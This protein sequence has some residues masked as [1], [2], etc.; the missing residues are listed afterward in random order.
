MIRYSHHDGYY[1]DIPRLH[2]TNES[3]I[4]HRV[5]IN[6]VFGGVEHDDDFDEDWLPL[7]FEPDTEFVVKD[8]YMVFVVSDEAFNL[9]RDEE[10]EKRM[11]HPP[12]EVTPVWQW[13]GTNF[14]LHKDL[15]G[16]EV[17]LQ[18]FDRRHQISLAAL[19]RQGC[20]SPDAP[21]DDVLLASRHTI[22]LYKPL[23]LGFIS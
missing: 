16:G 14:V 21:D 22:P 4:W 8:D 13:L 19:R 18:S 6:N 10:Y 15:S 3:F 1:Y 11:E 9:M 5:L 17:V 2:G 20:L 12:D 23:A 7:V